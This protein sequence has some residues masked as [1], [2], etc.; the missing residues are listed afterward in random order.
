MDMCIVSRPGAVNRVDD[1]SM[2]THTQTRTRTHT[3]THK[4]KHEHEHAY[5]SAHTARTYAPADAR[6]LQG[7]VQ[8]GAKKNVIF[9]ELF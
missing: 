1:P 8:D 7:G 4:H 6:K 3:H 9:L 5:A 2:Y